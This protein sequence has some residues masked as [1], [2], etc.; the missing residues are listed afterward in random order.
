[1][2]LHNVLVISGKPDLSELVSHTK[3]GAIVKNLVTGVKYPVFKN[4]RISAL[5]EIRMFAVDGETPLEDV[6]KNIYDKEQGKPVSIDYKK[7]DSTTLYDYFGQVMSNYDPDRVHVSDVK[8]VLS[9]YNILLEAGK[10]T[11]DNEPAEAVD[12]KVE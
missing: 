3:G 12:N 6:F 2:E 8:K 7:V 9:W 1:M 5:A 4:D 10:M 11:F